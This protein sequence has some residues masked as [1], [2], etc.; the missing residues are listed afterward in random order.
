MSTPEP[1]KIS[2]TNRGG[3]TRVFTVTDTAREVFGKPGHSDEQVAVEMAVA[4]RHTL[5]HQNPLSVVR[6]KD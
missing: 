3:K 6:V 1:A 2:I 4:A 5:R